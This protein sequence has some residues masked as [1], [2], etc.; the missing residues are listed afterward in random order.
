MSILTN[1]LS[2]VDDNRPA[3]QGLAPS[4][5][6]KQLNSSAPPSTTATIP[7][8]QQAKQYLQQQAEAKP[9]IPY[10]QSGSPKINSA[11][12]APPPTAA[13]Q[14]KTSAALN[15][16]LKTNPIIQ[17]AQEEPK[18]QQQPTQPSSMNELIEYLQGQADAEKAKMETPEQRA[19]RER[20][21]KWD[22]ITSGIGDAVSSLANLY[23]T[24]QYAPNMYNPHNTLSE[25]NQAR[26]DRA[27]ADR[28]ALRDNYINY[29]LKIGQLKDG[30]RDFQFKQQQAAAQQAQRDHD[31]AIADAKEERDAALAEINLQL[32]G[33]KITAA[34][35]EAK[36]KQA[37]ADY[38]QA[39]QQANLEK[40]KAQTAAARASAAASRARA[41]ESNARA[42]KTYHDMATSGGGRKEFRTGASVNQRNW[43]NDDYIEQLYRQMNGQMYYIGA[44]GKRHVVSTGTKNL[45]NNTNDAIAFETDRRKRANMMRG[46]IEELF[47][48]QYDAQAQ[49][50]MGEI[51]ADFDER[52][53]PKKK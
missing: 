38:A 11:N 18:V 9:Y 7:E 40:T 15:V 35:A 4:M 24:T 8:A 3:M 26:A 30:E 53:S 37:E 13:T 16:A 17:Q 6:G 2:R 20:R 44:D 49:D 42:A 25:A 34:E 51:M 23:F 33:Q 29:A 43:D 47:S 10:A 21:E 28:D 19:K 27:K 32:Q 41:G 50:T 14:P 12:S 45:F 39:L 5:A 31:N 46:A 36:K 22:K 48:N 52:Y 1:T